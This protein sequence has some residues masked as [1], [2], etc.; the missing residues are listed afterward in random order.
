MKI[1]IRKAFSSVM[2]LCIFAS[3]NAELIDR[4]EGFIQGYSG[5]QE[6]FAMAVRDGD[7]AAP[8]PEFPPRIDVTSLGESDGSVG[9]KLINP[10]ECFYPDFPPVSAVGD[11][12]DDGIDDLLVGCP[13]LTT[14]LYAVFGR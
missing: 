1:S 4:G 9:F 8:P 2:F 7:I 6:A 3:A 10:S 14:G 12:N 13:A 11:F 5:K